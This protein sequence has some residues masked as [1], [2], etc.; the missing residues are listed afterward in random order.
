M[1]AMKGN[2]CCV[3]YGD[4]YSLVL[5]MVEEYGKEY[6]ELIFQIVDG[7]REETLDGVNKA[8]LNGA[9]VVIA[10]GAN[11]KVVGDGYFNVPVI[12]YKVTPIDYLCAIQKG[13]KKGK[14]PA[15]VT[16]QK[17]LS[18]RFSDLIEQ[19]GVPVKEIIYEDTEDLE[20]KMRCSDADVVIGNA[21]AVDLAKKIGRK[22][23]LLYAGKESVQAAVV[24]ACSLIQE[25]RKEREK[26]A[27]VRAIL[28]G[29]PEGIL[30]LNAQ[31]EILECSKSACELIGMKKRSEPDQTKKGEGGSG[32]EKLYTGFTGEKL[33][34]I[35]PELMIA[36]GHEE[37]DCS[38]VVQS[39]GQKLIEHWISVE[40]EKGSWIGTTVLLSRFSDY[41]KMEM[42]YKKQQLER[43][44]EKGF[45]AKHTLKDIIGNSDCMR[46]CVENAALFAKS[47]ASVLIYG[48][49]G[50]GKELFAQGIHNASGRKNGPFVAI[51]CAALPENLLESELFGYDEGA[52]TGGRKGGKKG[53][54]ELADQGTLFL[55]EIGEISP[56]LQARL[57]RVLQEKEIMHIGG[58]RVIP[59]DV[60]IIAATNKN[61]EGMADQDFRRDLLYRL[62]VLE[63]RI[64]PLS[65]RG[66][67]VIDLFR[68][69]LER[70]YVIEGGEKTLGLTEEVCRILRR[71]SWKGNIRELQ[72]V[73][74]RYCLF[75]GRNPRGDNRHARRC[76]IRSI[77]EEKLIA[78][79][80]QVYGSDIEGMARELKDLLLYNNDQVSRALGISR[81][82]LWRL[83]RKD[84]LETE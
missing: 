51:N 73:C 1:K 82:T 25:I 84:D 27:F 61:L 22:Y 28:R 36:A 74:E 4:L 12:E 15:V 54:F 72:N 33:S 11:A 23:V 16:F 71:Y 43:R 62:N 70:K 67:D 47:D 52:F 68:F 34:R 55:D 29:S 6:P 57:L 65:K 38:A 64:P 13:Y 83:L 80:R 48:E 49:T 10:G 14:C 60:R 58:D 81:T 21:L 66:D 31:G 53:L 63:L 77:G 69:Y 42:D 44:K 46:M 76:M 2:I 24:E 20:R 19:L 8:I 7:L 56:P 26:N 3:T 32:I 50:T 78:E 30:Y 37:E 5:E 39:N 59:V 35:A 79:L 41:K 17:P 45:T 9:E 40:D 75:M 18:R